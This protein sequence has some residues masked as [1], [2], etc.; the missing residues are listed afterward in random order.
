MSDM[1]VASHLIL[2]IMY[3]NCKTGCSGNHCNFWTN[4]LPCNSVFGLYQVMHC[5]KLV[6]YVL[7]PQ[8]PMGHIKPDTRQNK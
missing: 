7:M 4:G 2:K 3:C 6:C 5:D 1:N 8:D